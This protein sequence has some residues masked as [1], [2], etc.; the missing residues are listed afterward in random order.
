[1]LR[2]IASQKQLS[3]ELK[4]ALTAA[5]KAFFDRL[6]GAEGQRGVASDKA[7]HEGTKTH[8]GREGWE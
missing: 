4:G 3:D 6:R 8:E 5:V 7:H 2:N 1:M